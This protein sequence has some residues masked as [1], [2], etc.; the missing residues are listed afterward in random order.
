MLHRELN[1][2]LT[3][4]LGR[5][6]LDRGQRWRII[7]L[8]PEA[9]L[10]VLEAVEGQSGIQLDQFGRA[11]HRAPNLRQIPLLDPGG[12]GLSADLEQLLGDLGPRG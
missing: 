5:T 12:G 11:S 8:L 6:W 1:N 3:G 2:R 7:D 9:G 10:L 4:L